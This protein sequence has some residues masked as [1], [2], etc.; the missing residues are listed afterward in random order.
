MRYT[1]EDNNEV[2]CVAFDA[3]LFN[4]DWSGSVEYRF[5]TPEAPRFLE[6][7]QKRTV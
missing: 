2:L 5:R 6:L 3:S 1:L 4:S 7:L